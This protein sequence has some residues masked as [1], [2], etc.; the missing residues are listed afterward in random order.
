MSFVSKVEASEEQRL[1]TTILKNESKLKS[2]KSLIKSAL[3]DLESIPAKERSVKVNTAKMK[4][5]NIF[6]MYWKD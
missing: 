5:K 2:I 1:A 3:A 6:S 4:L